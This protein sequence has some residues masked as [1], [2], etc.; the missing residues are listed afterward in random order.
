M[1]VFVGAKKVLYRAWEEGKKP[2][3]GRRTR[4]AD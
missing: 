2:A 4:Q 3:R 1:V